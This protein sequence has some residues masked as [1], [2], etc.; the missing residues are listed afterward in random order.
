MIS[1]LQILFL[2]QLPDLVNQ[3]AGREFRSIHLAK[4]EIPGVNMFLDVQS[5]AL[6]PDHQSR[7]SFIEGKKRRTAALLNRRHSVTNRDGG[8]S[9]AGRSQQKRTG[10]AIKSSAQQVV[11]RRESAFELRR[12]ECKKVLR[13]HEA[14]VNFHAAPLDGVVVKS[15]AEPRTAQ[16]LHF[17]PASFDAVLPL[18]AF[19]QD[20]AVSDA[21]ELQI[22][23]FGG[24]IIQ[25]QHGAFASRK[26]LLQTQ[27]LPAIA[28]GIARQQAQLREG[29]KHNAGW[30]QPLHLR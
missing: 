29:V 2:Y 10:A 26:V 14:R 15:L 9:A 7:Q 21:L 3:L 30:L 6:S 22:V 8:F 24:A 4:E 5:Q 19:H 1:S 12:R 11:Q 13:G 16:L 25:Q 18:H 27:N 28:Q 23:S 20:H 17:Q